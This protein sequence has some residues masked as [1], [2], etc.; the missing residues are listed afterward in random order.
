MDHQTFSPSPMSPNPLCPSPVSNEAAMP[1]FEQTGPQISFFEFWPISRFYAPLMIWW[2]ILSIRYRGFTL[3][4]IANPS[5]PGGGLVGES[6]SKVFEVATGAMKDCIPPWILVSPLASPG[7]QEKSFSFAEIEQQKRHAGLSYPLVAKPDIGCRGAGVQPIAKD[8]DLKRYLATFPP[9]ASFILQEQ[10]LAPGEAG[11]YYMRRPGEKTG[12]I[13]SITLKYFPRVI[14]DG[15]RT[16]R[17]LI[18]D[19]PRAGKLSH[20]YLERHHDHLDDILPAGQPFV[21]VFSGSHSKGTIFR[22]GTAYRTDALREKFD[23]LT[24]D[25]PGF[26]VGRFDVRFQ[27]YKALQRGED[28]MILEINGAGGEMTHIWDR[29]MSLLQAYKA[30]FLQ[31]KLLFEIGARHRR[32]G[33]RPWSLKRLVQAY[34]HELALQKHYPPTL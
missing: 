1:P 19:E 3:P 21:L 14:G 31:Y 10:V 4:T 15:K 34:R 29:N 25:L 13:L 17:E 18:L 2:L 9:N 23:S 6:K 28:F 16:L 30:L 33:H 7:S 26:Y 24:K 8:A 11:I 32:S 5:F 12:Q 22:D 20:I 27:D